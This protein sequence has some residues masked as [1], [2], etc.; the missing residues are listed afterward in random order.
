MYKWV[1]IMF[2]MQRRS[3]G[4]Q[5]A[6]PPPNWPYQR[7]FI[8]LYIYVAYFIHLKNL[9]PVSAFLNILFLALTIFKSW[10]CHWLY[11]ILTSRS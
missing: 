1:F 6:M 7:I 9:L 2:Y 3:Q 11:G 10:L 5:W 8:Y 4:G